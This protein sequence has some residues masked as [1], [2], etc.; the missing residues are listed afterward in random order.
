MIQKNDITSLRLDKILLHLLFPCYVGSYCA[1][2]DYNDSVVKQHDETDKSYCSEEDLPDD[3]LFYEEDEEDDVYD[4]YSYD[5]GGDFV[6]ALSVIPEATNTTCSTTAFCSR[7]ITSRSSHDCVITTKI[8][9]NASS[10]TLEDVDKNNSKISTISVTLDVMDDCRSSGIAQKW[11]CIS[12]SGSRIVSDDNLVQ[13]IFY[14]KDFSSGSGRARNND[15]SSGLVSSSMC[16]KNSFESLVRNNDTT[17]S[18]RSKIQG[19]TY[20]IITI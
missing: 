11:E 16:E 3:L 4:L 1:T 18:N 5:R 17:K 13:N 14:C 20:S 9:T 19:S 8:L 15:T 6:S 7:D 10:L 2:K 12:K